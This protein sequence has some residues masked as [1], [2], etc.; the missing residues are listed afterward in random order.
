MSEHEEA[1]KLIVFR[2]DSEFPVTKRQKATCKCSGIRHEY[3]HDGIPQVW[4]DEHTRD[5]ECKRCGARIDPFDYLWSLATE[6]LG[7]MRELLKLR[8]QKETLRAQIS[9]MHEELKEVRSV[10]RKAKRE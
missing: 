3:N 5:L 2:P 4:I 1:S 9:L 10:N 8:E 6:G 7:L